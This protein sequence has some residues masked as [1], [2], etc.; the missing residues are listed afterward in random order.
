[1]IARRLVCYIVNYK[2]ADLLHALSLVDR[3]VY[4]RVY[5][6][7]CDVLD[8]RVHRPRKYPPKKPSRKVGGIREFSQASLRTFFFFGGGGNFLGPWTFLEVWFWLDM[9][10]FC[11]YTWVPLPASN[12]CARAI[13]CTV[14]GVILVVYVSSCKREYRVSAS[15][16]SQFSQLL[17]INYYSLLTVLST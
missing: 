7:G 12:P 13:L 2:I 5:K 1:M 11:Y 4:M 17:E 6:H 14:A 3:C 16:F 10:F 8:S 15:H 9:T